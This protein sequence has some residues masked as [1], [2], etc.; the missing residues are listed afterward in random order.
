MTQGGV[1]QK[2]SSV[3][4]AAG[5]TGGHLFPA[6]AAAQALKKLDPYLLITI[7]SDKEISAQEKEQ[8][9][10]IPLS[11]P[12]RSPSWK[13]PLFIIALGVAFLKCLLQFLINRPHVVVGFGGYPSV[14]VVLAAQVLGVSTMMHEQNAYLGLANRLL[15]K[16]AKGI[17]L[18][19]K[20]TLAVPASAKTYVTGNPVR[21]SSDQV[22]QKQQPPFRL[23][24]LGGSQGAAI[25]SHVIPAAFSLLSEE[26]RS[27]FKLTMQ[28]RQELLY[29]T[30]AAFSA[31]GMQPVLQSFFQDMQR[32][33]EKSDFII[34]RSG[35]STVSEVASVGRA[36]FFV[37]YLYAADDHQYY[38]AKAF[39][40]ACFLK[41][42]QELT[43]EYIAEMLRKIIQ[44][45][46]L[47]VE[48]A[49]SIHTYSMK[50][51]SMSLA[52]AVQDLLPTV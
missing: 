44:S 4:F 52:K 39:G 32:E 23:F 18:S 9:A 41:R 7:A 36:A 6:L 49:K 14:P 42:Q 34:S 35:A 15:S 50:N 17:A 33:Y 21:F 26:E 51:A 31:L 11:I 45:P 19:F 5:G 28:C 30:T 8:F 25:F 27:F 38:N 43:P 3:V 46:D 24:V 47:L 40:D 22:Y 29:K 1:T 48:K 37:P 20:E 2:K 10:Y 16:R 12:R 13:L